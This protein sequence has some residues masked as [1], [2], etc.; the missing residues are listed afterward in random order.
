MKRLFEKVKAM[1]GIRS[2]RY[3]KP[4][5]SRDHMAVDLSRALQ[6]NERASQEAREALEEVLNRDKMAD[7]FRDIVGKM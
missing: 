3:E 1:L 4:V 2:A 6:R 5:S 7:T